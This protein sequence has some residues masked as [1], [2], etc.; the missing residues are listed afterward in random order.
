[1]LLSSLI[2]VA[3]HLNDS[4]VLPSESD[5]KRRTFVH[6]VY[7]LSLNLKG[8]LHCLASAVQLV[9][10]VKFWGVPAVNSDAMN[11]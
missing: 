5:G 8:N 1:M 6:L 3:H 4:S 7:S 9:V 11:F 2:E 10:S